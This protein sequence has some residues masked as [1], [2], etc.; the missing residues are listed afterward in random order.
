MR[1]KSWANV[2]SLGFKDLGIRF[3]A[4]ELDDYLLR[5]NQLAVI[6][7][8]REN[9]LRRAISLL[10]LHK[11]GRVLS[12]TGD[13]APRERLILDVDELLSMM[14]IME[15]EK[16]RQLVLVEQ[17]PPDRVY[18]LSYEQMFET[19]ESMRR[20]LRGMFELLDVAPIHIM[21]RH[22][23]ILSVDLTETISNF[24][25]VARAVSATRFHAHLD[26]YTGAI[27]QG[28][29]QD[30]VPGLDTERDSAAIDLR[31]STWSKQP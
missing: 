4:H 17:L 28:A 31:D 12:R 16:E 2:S 1:D 20:H 23:R 14:E 11:T 18:S 5:R 6:N 10:S 7:L 15:R 25:E 22:E 21:T 3:S 13:D 19:P 27:G 30:R 29:T 8:Y 9:T 26:N 24:S